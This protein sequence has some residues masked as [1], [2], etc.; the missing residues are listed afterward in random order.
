MHEFCHGRKH[1]DR[2]DAFR[3]LSFLWEKEIKIMQEFQSHLK[4]AALKFFCVFFFGG[5]RMSDV[6]TAELMVLNSYS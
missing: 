2:R 1:S 4:T 6:G 5:G 3:G